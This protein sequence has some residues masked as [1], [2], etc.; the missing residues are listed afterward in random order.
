MNN[1][2]DD[3]D[4]VEIKINI[5]LDIFKNNI[6]KNCD[7]NILIIGIRKIISGGD[8][9][10]LSQ[11]LYTNLVSL[12]SQLLKMADSDE[13]VRSIKYESLWILTNLACGK[14]SETMIIID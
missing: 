1:I 10:P 8:E 2:P 11:A 12:V 13:Y 9:V 5:I 3:L 14:E 6:L 7:S 4:H